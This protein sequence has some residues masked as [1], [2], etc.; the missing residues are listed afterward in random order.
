MSEVTILQ[1]ASLIALVIAVTTHEASHGYMAKAFGDRT[2]EI[3]GRLTFNPIA[4][5]DLIGTI[6]LPAFLYFTGSPFLFGY[7]KPVPVD[8]RNLHPRRW[9]EALVAL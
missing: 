8:F 9:G 3:M 1:I 6:L 7:A 2:A 4:H 5:I